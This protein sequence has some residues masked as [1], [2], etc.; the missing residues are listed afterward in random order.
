MDPNSEL[1]RAKQQVIYYRAEIAQYKNKIS[2]LER[3]VEKEVV[4]NKYLQG[5]IQ[6]LNG[7]KIAGLQEEIQKL[8]MRVMELE[9]EL[10]EEKNIQNTSNSEL[11]NGGEHTKEVGVEF[12]SYFNYSVIL[13]PEGDDTISI[14]GDFTIVNTGDVPLKDVVVCFKVTPVG[15]VT[16]SGKISDPK[17]LNGPGSEREDIE[18][19]WAIEDWRDRIQKKGEHW[20]KPIRSTVAIKITLNAFEII[21]SEDACNGKVKVDSFVYSDNN[22]PPHASLNKIYFQIP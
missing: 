4:R 9:V 14:Y 13:P 21:F 1:F 2:E 17:L 16:L 10:E 8:R 15:S 19:V 5:K 11:V 22:T 7:E 18:W 12:Y 6:E 3:L 20:V